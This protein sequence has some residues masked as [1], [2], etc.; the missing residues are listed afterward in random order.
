MR[1]VWGNRRA[2]GSPR[3]DIAGD[4]LAQLWAASEEIVGIR[5]EPDQVEQFRRYL[6]L[7]V[8]WNRVHRLTGPKAPEAV[9]RELFLDALLFLS[10][11]PHEPILLADIGSGAGIPGVPIRIL[12]PDIRTTLVESKRKRVSFLSAV[13]RELELGDLSILEGRAESV[14]RDTRGIEASFDVVLSRGVGT[15]LYE[16]ALL[17]LKPGGLYVAGAPPVTLD[18]GVAPGCGL[19]VETVRVK[20]F[21]IVRSFLIGRKRD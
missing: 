10:R 7:I 1:S 9:V 21:G 15:A 5:A 8:Q 3:S 19:S 14:L 18:R 6:A 20:R 4:P 17:Y 2:S 12:R 11:V 16:T 13:K